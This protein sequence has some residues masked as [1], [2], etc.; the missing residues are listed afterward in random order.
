VKAL[1]LLAIVLSAVGC[2]HFAPWVARPLMSPEPGLYPP[3]KVYVRLA[4]STPDSTIYYTTDGTQPTTSSAAYSGPIALTSTSTVKA[5]SVR[6]DLN[7][8]YIMSGTYTLQGSQFTLAGRML[9]AG[10]PLANQIKLQPSISFYARWSAKSPSDV[11]FYYDEESSEYSCTNLPFE[12]TQLEIRFSP[13]AVSMYP[14]N[15]HAWVEPGLDT[16]SASAGLSYDINVNVLMH[17]LS[18]FDNTNRTVE[19]VY[20]THTSPVAFSWEAVPSASSYSYR[21]WKRRDGATSG[22]SSEVIP[23]TSIGATSVSLPLPSSAANEHY[24]FFLR[25][26]DAADNG[27]GEIMLIPTSGGWSSYYSFKVP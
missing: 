18:P 8:S 1:L 5:L 21:I 13:T 11:I 9:Y 16:M 3:V 25:A 26:Y 2:D 24:E 6:P 14:G 23:L 17:L 7:D 10:Q 20:S 4:S 19:G 22:G 15:Y 12:P 27:L